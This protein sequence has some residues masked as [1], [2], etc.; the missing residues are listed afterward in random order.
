M[1][2]SREHPADTQAIAMMQALQQ[3]AI[4]TKDTR[5]SRLNGTISRNCTSCEQ[6]ATPCAATRM[7][8]LVKTAWII[9][10]YDI[11]ADATDNAGY[12]SSRVVLCHANVVGSFTSATSEANV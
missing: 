8:L 4:A 2:F 11:L 6:D 12:L 9:I 1:V 5:F 3:T 7:A 10:S